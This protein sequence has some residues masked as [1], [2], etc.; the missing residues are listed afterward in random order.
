MPATVRVAVVT[1]AASGIGRATASRLAREGYAVE[2]VDRDGPAVADAASAWPGA[3]AHVVDVAD[4]AA[5]DRLAADVT[6]RRGAIRALV[7]CAGVTAVKPWG[8]HTADDVAW[9]IGVNLLGTMH[10]CRAFLP[11]LRAHG[12]GARIVNLSSVA[13]FVPYPG[14]TAYCASKFGVTGFSEALRLELGP[15]GIGVSVIHP[16]GIKTGILA[17]ARFA[18]GD[19]RGQMAALMDRYGL[20]ADAVARAASR[21]I[22]GDRGRWLV[23]PDAWAIAAMR[24]VAPTLAAWVLDRGVRRV[25]PALS[26]R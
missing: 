12:A 22:D 18:G 3:T 14:Q 23:G 17:G 8:D 19:A 25:I 1:G 4:P 5:V 20:D 26:A 16:G 6:A 13:G 10:T 15:E 7:N 9:V 24:R 2:A 11:A 21:A